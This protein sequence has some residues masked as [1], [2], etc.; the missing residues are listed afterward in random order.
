MVTYSININNS[1]YM[2]SKI[3]ITFL[4]VLLCMSVLTT[5]CDD[6]IDV[7]PEDAIDATAFFSNA[8]EL[9]FAVNGLYSSQRGIYG[10]NLLYI[11]HEGRSDNVIFADVNSA[12]AVDQTLDIFAEQSTNNVLVT[13]WVNHYILINNANNVLKNARSVPFENQVEEALIGRSV[14]EAK[15]LR[16]MT[17]FSLVTLWGSVPL[18]TDPT[19][20]FDNAVVPRSTVSDVYALI[21][22]DLTEAVAALPTSYSGGKFNEVGRATRYTAQALLGKVHLQNGNPSAASTVLE[23]VIAGGT[24]ALLSDYADIHAAGN[25]NTAE[26]IFEVS[27]N[28]ENNTGLNL[29]NFF[30]PISVASDL[31]IVAGGFSELPP[32]RPTANVQSIYEAGDMRAAASF[33]LF[34]LDGVQTPYISKYIDLDAAGQGSDINLVLLRY[35]DV[36]L[37][38]AEADGENAASYELINQVRRRAFGQDPDAPDPAIDIDAS[39]PG[40][41]TEKL[42]LERRREFAFEYQ[43]WPDLLRL[44]D[45][46]VIAIMNDHLSAE[47]PGIATPIDDHNLIYPIPEFEIETSNG[48]VDQNDGY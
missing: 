24:Y 26:S 14:A 47:L 32:Y 23:D 2:P 16:A 6:F 30:I 15:F 3:R 31:G 37:M 18:R 43:R 5:S 13:N 45:S 44:P 7:A 39:T 41:F 38:K 46:D 19:E 36:L 42:Q 21:I 17:Y 11:M 34:D 22:L 28:P 10:S 20:D 8:D 27:F 48:V 29:N 9:V 40:T 1:N 35:A 33:Q 12:N 4:L 25:D